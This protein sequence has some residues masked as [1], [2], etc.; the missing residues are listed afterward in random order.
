MIRLKLNL[1]EGTVNYNE[2][3][4]LTSAAL[5]NVPNQIKSFGI[6]VEIKGYIGPKSFF[7]YSL[8]S[9]ARAFTINEQLTLLRSVG[10]ATVPYVMN[11][12]TAGD[13]LISTKN[14][15]AQYDAKWIN[16][17]TGDEFK[18]PELIQIKKTAWDLLERTLV[19]RME[20]SDG[21]TYTRAD[22]RDMAYYQPG[23]MVKL[24]NNQLLPYQTSHMINPI[25]CVCPNCNNPLKK[26]QI[27]SDLPL[28]YKCTS[29]FCE[30]IVSDPAP[31]VT[32]TGAVEFEK[33]ST[34]PV[35]AE[36]EVEE[37][38]PK[39]TDN[40]DTELETVAETVSG[41]NITEAYQPEVTVETVDSETV[42]NSVENVESGLIESE[43][44]DKDTIDDNSVSAESN[45]AELKIETETAETVEAEDETTAEEEPVVENPVETVEEPTA[46][47]KTAKK[48]LVINMDCGDL[49]RPYDCVEYTE[50][51]TAKADYILAQRKGGNKNSQALS[52]ETGIDII[53]IAELEALING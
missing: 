34:E 26:V 1:E 30:K 5:P 48:L 45:E 4:Q 42:E 33:E 16:T 2:Q 36:K 37:V 18:V 28:F 14:Q 7:V 13:S 35:A 41:E 9:T 21:K 19:L 20:C 3:G 50:D 25:P 12:N 17:V 23:N 6:P 22:L 44:A 40:A 51:T 27:Y 49:A 10:F 43:N 31:A 46:E 24:F 11:E 39:G 52:A 29:P 32:E 53:S 38:S 8:T 47:E 15:F